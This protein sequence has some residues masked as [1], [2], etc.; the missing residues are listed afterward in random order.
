MT[1]KFNKKKI[2]LFP[3]FKFIKYLIVFIILLSS[4]IFFYNEF[5]DKERFFTFINNISAKF[6]YQFS[7]L[8]I[9]SL[10][11]V[12]KNQV[13]KIINN[14][15]QQSIFLIPLNDISNALYE[16]KWIK[17]VNISKNFKNKIKV[18]IIEF[19][20]VGLFSYNDQLYYFSKNGKIIDKYIKNNNENFIIFHGKHALKEANNFLINLNNVENFRV[21]IIKEAHYI[22]KRRWD[23]KLNN[24]IILNLSEKNIEES[25]NNYMKLIEKLNDSEINSI[26]NIDLR[27]NLKA[28]ISYK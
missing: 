24:N 15:L 8:E 20:P 23:I 6:N 1:T 27:N 4:V 22:N 25:I 14:Y 7:I 10:N 5:K 13:S 12:D 11:R 19:L 17:S 9:N 18:E 28:I 21:L 26:K 16:L 2:I 3:N